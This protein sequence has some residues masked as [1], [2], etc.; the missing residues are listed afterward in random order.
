MEMLRIGFPE[1]YKTIPFKYSDWVTLKSW[2]DIASSEFQITEF[3]QIARL[4]AIVGARDIKI[5]DKTVVLINSKVSDE[6][7]NPIP[8]RRKY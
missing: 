1:K 3:G 7:A 4:A 6:K 8:E 5:K 2:V